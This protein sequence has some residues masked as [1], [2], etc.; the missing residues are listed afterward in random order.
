MARR[1]LLAAAVGLSLMAIALVGVLSFDSDEVEDV[2]R[3]GTVSTTSSTEAGPAPGP[4]GGVTTTAPG[5]PL[6]TEGAAPVAGAILSVEVDDPGAPV[7]VGEETDCGALDPASDP[8]ACVRADGSG[9]EFL[10]Y[11]GRTEGGGLQTRLYRPQGG[12]DDFVLARRSQVFARGGDVIGLALA[13]A[14]VGGEVVVVID[15]DF[16]GSGAVHSFDV[17]A[18]DSSDVD[19]RVVA[20]VNG[21]GGD[22]H[23]RDGEALAFVGANYDDGAPTCCPT[24]ADVRSL[25]HEGPGKWAITKKTVP[26]A[27]AP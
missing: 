7:D 13:E 4:A 14:E 22:R 23:V 21:T 16:G 2:A 8:I 15:Y 6:Q 5:A 19:P 11:A 26:F 18:W 9:G 12:G 25:N 27:Q 17:V 1:V 10:V 3:Q 24:R 20:F